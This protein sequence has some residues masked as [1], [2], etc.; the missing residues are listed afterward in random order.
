MGNGQILEPLLD[1]SLSR[2]SLQGVVVV[3][4]RD[5]M[6][7]KK[8]GKMTS[9]GRKV[10]VG[11]RYRDFDLLSGTHQCEIPAKKSG[12]NGYTKQSGMR[13][14]EQRLYYLR[15]PD[16]RHS[17]H[18]RPGDSVCKRQMHDIS[19]VVVFRQGWMQGTSR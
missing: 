3:W 2:L 7:E 16:Y 13:A 5:S 17:S 11:M 9:W 19:G 8:G 10:G 12:E 1:P 15:L 4:M 18:P 6:R 14:A